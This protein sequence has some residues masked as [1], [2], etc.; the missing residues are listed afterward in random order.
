MTINK[1]QQEI[2]QFTLTRSEYADSLGISPNC[3]RMRMRHGKYFPC[4]I[5]IRTQLG[6]IPRLSAYS[7]LVRVN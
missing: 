4:R 3:V 6:L 5:L 7:D 1:G 2:D